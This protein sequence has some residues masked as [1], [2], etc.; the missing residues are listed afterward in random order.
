MAEYRV[1]IIGSGA[2][3]LAVARAL[4]RR[5]I[6][7]DQF[8]RHSE[9]GGIWDQNNPGGPMY[10]SAHMISSKT[11]SAFMG[12][13]MPADYPDYP[14]HR[15]VAAY[16]RSFANAYDLR[17][18]IEFNV[19]VVSVEKRRN[20]WV[21]SLSDGS[22][23]HY[24]AVIA[25]TGLA[26]HPRMPAYP[27]S[28][29]G[30]MIHS[31]A[32]RAPERFKG[33]R[34]LVIGAGNSGVDIASDA[35][36]TADRVLLSMRRAYNFIPKHIF[37]MPA[38][39]FA[40]T[41]KLLPIRLQQWTFALVL[42]LLNGDVTR[43]GLK[44]PDHL[45]LASHPIVNSSAL[46]AMAHGDLTPKVDIE[47]SEV[48]FKDGTREEVD[49]VVA[50]TGY[51][52]KIPF[53]DQALVSNAGRES[54]LF[55]RSISR[56]DPSF[57]A[58]GFIELNGGVWPFYD[59]FADIIAAYHAERAAGTPKAAAFEAI[60]KSG[61]LEVAGPI[62][63]VDSP[64]HKVYANA[65]TSMKVLARLRRRMGWA[66]P[67]AETMAPTRLTFS[68]APRPALQPAE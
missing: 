32:Y 22:I 10:D 64:R 48:V 33:K 15:Q 27:G 26:W 28:F 16:L 46:L 62:D 19:E 58:M 30:E 14:S 54:N 39:V 45:P 35:A 38:D 37:G 23:R 59:Q 9:V 8:E 66:A 7:Y 55:L 29:A 18:S 63:Y 17:R 12:Y 3:G 5:L 11:M 67:R 34:V 2:G 42:R 68:P 51:V 56:A 44:R 53:A 60:V 21:V 52:H 24:D 50:A 1:C 36:R 4:R 40:L 47:R 65:Q 25:S 41:G 61:E 49:I 6:A 20:R 57:A 13:P 31:S 43:Y